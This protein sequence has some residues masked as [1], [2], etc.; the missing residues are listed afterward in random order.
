M[1][2]ENIKKFL[3]FAFT[4]ERLIALLAHTQDRKLSY[5][6]CCCLIGS[7]NAPHA[8]RGVIE[9]MK[10]GRALPDGSLHHQGL[11]L[12]SEIAAKAEE[13]F[14]DIAPTDALRCEVLQPLI[15]AEILRRES[16]S[17]VYVSDPGDEQVGC[18]ITWGTTVSR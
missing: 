18:S 5:H 13:E 12:T 2:T 15:E 9:E 6:S 10:Q 17:H 4:D 7:A 3:E 11:R 14:F 8:L 1:K 16:E